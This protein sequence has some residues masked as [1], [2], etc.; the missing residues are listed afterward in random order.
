[1]NFR[2]GQLTIL[3]IALVAVARAEAQDG[4]NSLIPSFQSLFK[5]ADIVFLGE[6]HS[7]RNHKQVFKTVLTPLVE[8]GTIDTVAVEFVQFTDNDLLL[9]YLN[10]NAAT[11][12]SQ[13]ETQFFLKLSNCNRKCG[14]YSR[15]GGSGSFPIMDESYGAVLREM[16]R[17]YRSRNGKIKFCG[18]NADQFYKNQFYEINSDVAGLNLLSEPFKKLGSQI[19]GRSLLPT[20]NE[21]GWGSGS[22]RELR[23]AAGLASCLAQSQKALVFTGGFHA[24]QFSKIKSSHPAASAYSTVADLMAKTSGKRVASG[25]IASSSENNMNESADGLYGRNF[26]RKYS[27]PSFQ[28]KSVAQLDPALIKASEEDGLPFLKMYDYV[29]FGPRSSETEYTYEL[30]TK[31]IS[32]FPIE[33]GELTAIALAR[34]QVDFQPNLNLWRIDGRTKI[35]FSLRSPGRFIFQFWGQIKQIKLNGETVELSKISIAPSSGPLMSPIYILNVAL[36]AHTS[37]QIE[38]E[39]QVPSGGYTIFNGANGKL[40][41]LETRYDNRFGLG[42]QQ[43]FPTVNLPTTNPDTT[44]RIL[45]SSDFDVSSLGILCRCNTSELPNGIALE[46]G[47]I[48]SQQMFFQARPKALNDLNY[49]FETRS[50]LKVT[51]RLNHFFLDNEY[52]RKHKNWK[53]AQ[54][55]LESDLMVPMRKVISQTLERMESAI[56]EYP[57]GRELALTV[58]PEYNGMSME[59][60]GA[61]HSGLGLLVH[62]IIH[63]WFATSV[64]PMTNAD[65]WFMESITTWLETRKFDDLRNSLEP[66]YKKRDPGYQ[67][68]DRSE[69]GHWD[70]EAGYKTLFDQKFCPSLE[71]RDLCEGFSF[72]WYKMGPSLLDQINT[73]LV[74][75]SSG[76][77]NLTMVLKEFFE[78]YRG[79]FVTVEELINLL[80]LKQPSIDWEGFLAFS[81]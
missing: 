79:R 50:N 67:S 37:Y 46:F 48:P 1:M 29:I 20:D 26:Q 74:T 45:N 10:D 60:R 77:L 80:K 8:S 59:Y 16:H 41:T 72:D 33:L 19:F 52:L 51:V 11:N 68:S 23:L 75:S 27:S 55:S 63:Q 17:L 42:A 22:L 12:G 15:A 64:M 57:H 76:S 62:E 30:P 31:A 25:T 6:Y 9:E 28:F 65:N 44:V 4:L 43:L 70:A 61:I 71:R 5:S 36:Q 7:M 34:Q 3:F 32:S 49:T 14:T 39:F 21:Y 56:G 69:S 81:R 38:I 13:K 35:D 2:T 53:E 40:L 58:H 73:A 78:H 54:K 47:K 24:M 18:I 66:F